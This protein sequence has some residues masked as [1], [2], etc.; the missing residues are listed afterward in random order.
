MNLGF[1]P[2]ELSNN[3]SAPSCCG[4]LIFTAIF[5]SSWLHKKKID[6]LICFILAI[7]SFITL[8]ISLVICYVTIGFPTHSVKK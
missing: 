3:Y 6:S 8:W 7:L 2:V 5:P 1:E 4:F